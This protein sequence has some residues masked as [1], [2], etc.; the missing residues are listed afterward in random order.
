MKLAF[1]TPKSNKAKNRFSNLME[2]NPECIVEQIKDNRA[3][4]RSKNGKNFFWVDINNNAHWG[5]V[6]G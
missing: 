1:V 2:K 6:L 3:F 5:V 4:L